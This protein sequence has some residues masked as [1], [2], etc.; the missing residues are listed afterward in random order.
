MNK[1]EKSIDKVI[2]ILYNLKKGAILKTKI[3]A[4]QRFVEIP[5]KIGNV[6]N[7]REFREKNK[8]KLR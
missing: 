3:T 6:I 2:F 1:T 4:G 5:F 7:I 8:M